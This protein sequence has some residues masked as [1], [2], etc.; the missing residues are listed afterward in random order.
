MNS[1]NLIYL[2]IRKIGL[3]LGLNAVFNNVHRRSGA[4][5]FDRTFS[6]FTSTEHVSNDRA[7]SGVKLGFKCVIKV[8]KI[9]D[10]LGS[11]LLGLQWI[12]R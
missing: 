10:R 1:R 3:S 12:K 4:H 2:H 7:N 8:S 6:T 9:L 5:H 11:S